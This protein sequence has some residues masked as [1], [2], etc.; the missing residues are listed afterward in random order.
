M[1]DPNHVL[2]DKYP[3]RLKEEDFDQQ[4]EL[5]LELVRVEDGKGSWPRGSS[6]TIGQWP[7]CQKRS[8]KR[9]RIPKTRADQS[10]QIGSQK[11]T[12]AAQTPKAIDFQPDPKPPSANPPSGSRRDFLICS[13]FSGRAS[14]LC[15]MG[16]GS[17][18]NVVRVCTC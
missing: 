1:L 16:G 7:G 6:I 4:G 5:H 12:G 3:L 18:S 15:P 13:P 17:A 8:Q 14:L 9:E 10:A 11:Q 2:A